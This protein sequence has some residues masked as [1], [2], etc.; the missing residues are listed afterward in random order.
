MTKVNVESAIQIKTFT[1]DLPEQ[2]DVEV[3]NFL[4]SIETRFVRDVKVSTNYI[5]RNEHTGY[6]AVVTYLY[7]KVKGHTD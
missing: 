5:N 4:K 1:A 6:T 7:A 2:L 3:N